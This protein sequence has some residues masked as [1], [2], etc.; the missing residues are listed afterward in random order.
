M[1]IPAEPAIGNPAMAARDATISWSEAASNETQFLTQYKLGSG[2]WQAGPSVGSGTRSVTIGGLIPGESYTFQVGANN[3][4]GTRWSAYATGS[5][6]QVLASQV[7]NASVTATSETAAALAWTNT[8]DNV[9]SFVTQYRVTGTSAWTAGPSVGAGT[10]SVTV[11][12][13]N[14]RHQVHVPGR[15]GEQ[16]GHRLGPVLLRHHGERPD[17]GT[18]P[19][20]VQHR[21]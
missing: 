7:T 8:A 12:G 3:I 14:G 2:A 21:A 16:Q 6:P 19:D 11:G 10:T 4:A 5:T 18:G 15:G 20:G 13:L 9:A 17:S 1:P